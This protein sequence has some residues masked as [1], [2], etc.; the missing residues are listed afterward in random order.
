MVGLL[1]YMLIF[2]QLLLLCWNVKIFQLCF[3]KKKEKKR[4]IRNTV[5]HNEDVNCSQWG[6]KDTTGIRGESVH[7]I[8]IHSF[9]DYLLSTCYLLGSL[10]HTELNKTELPPLETGSLNGRTVI[11]AW[12]SRS[13]NSHSDFHTP[14][15]LGL[16]M[17]SVILSLLWE[18]LWKPDSLPSPKTKRPA[19]SAE[20][21][22]GGR[23]GGTGLCRHEGLSSPC[24]LC[25]HGLLSVTQASQV[26]MGILLQ[27]FKESPYCSP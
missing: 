27:H 25:S 23:G 20:G 8:F 10:G 3:L 17:E 12:T 13:L 5:A 11:L 19:W 16:H 1:L 15:L 26:V 2:Y 7:L 22:G 6:E 21:W 18:A 4:L 9:K 24:S 14:A